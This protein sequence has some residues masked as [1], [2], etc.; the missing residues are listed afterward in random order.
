MNNEMKKRKF[1]IREKDNLIVLSSVILR[2]KF[3]KQRIKKFIINEVY[4]TP[5]IPSQTCK[6]CQKNKEWI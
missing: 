2:K 5:R 1:P 6:I 3:K 4:K